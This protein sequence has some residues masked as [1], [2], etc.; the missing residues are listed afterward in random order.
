MSRLGVFVCHCGSNIGD[1][2]DCRSVA[3]YARGL[4]GVSVALDYKY[5][6]SDP[7][8]KMITDAITEKDLTGVVVAS[9]S[10]RMHEPTFR[11]NVSNAGLN[12]YLCEM[13][14]LREHCSWVHTDRDRATAKAMDLVRFMVEK[15]KKNQPLYDIKVPVTKRALVIGGGIAGIQAAL[16][17]AAGGHEVVLVEK[18]ASIGGHMAQLDETFP[19]LDCSQCILTPKMVDAAQSDKISLHTYSEVEAVDGYIGNFEITIKKKAR[20]V[21]ADKCTGC[22]TCWNHCPVH[23]IPN[24]DKKSTPVEIEELS[25]KKEVD[26]I[27]DAYSG[28]KGAL[29]PILQDID[30]LYRYLPKELLQYVSFRLEIPMSQ[31]LH[32]ATFYTAFSLE[33]RGKHTIHVC[34]GTACHV[35]GAPRLLDEIG[36]ELSI[37][38]GETTKDKLFTLETVN[39]LGACAMGPVMV[40]DGTYFGNMTSAKVGKVLEKYGKD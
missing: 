8:Q 6:C 7:G 3:N 34:M 28:Q 32:M 23:N 4:R 5:M 22:G 39:C 24:F 21:N 11:K 38:P 25:R 40:I 2:V 27:I 33:P 36:R 12:P 18:D 10:P 19:T 9:C 13:A 30:A 20:S 14:N 15:V 35:R 17:I 1:R 31:V 37:E 29:I 26:E 16:D